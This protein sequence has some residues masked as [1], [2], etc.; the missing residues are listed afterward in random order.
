MPSDSMCL[1]TSPQYTDISPREGITPR[2]FEERDTY[3][4]SR[5]GPSSSSATSL[6]I[7]T[8]DTS[9]DSCKIRSRPRTLSLRMPIPMRVNKSPRIISYKN[10][11]GASHPIYRQLVD[12]YII[13][14]R[15]LLQ[16]TRSNCDRSKKSNKH[17]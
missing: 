8:T 9:S 4:K 12:T 14:I 11:L 3:H 10:A 6:F 7:S 5:E 1:S 2:K 13:Q 15:L 17:F 16:C